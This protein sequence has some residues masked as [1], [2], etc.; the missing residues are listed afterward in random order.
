MAEGDQAPDVYT[1]IPP[2][3]EPK[4][5]GALDFGTGGRSRLA[6]LLRLIRAHP[7]RLPEYMVLFA[8]H[9]QAPSVRE[10]AA[11]HPEDPGSPEHD[12]LL[13]EMRHDLLAFSRING[14]LSGTPFF[15]ALVPAYVSVLRE[16]ARMALRIGALHGRDPGAP[17]RPA[18]A[19]VLL[20]IYPT[21]QAAEDRLE[22]IRAPAAAEEKTGLRQV[23][24]LRAWI[25]VVTQVL[26]LAGFIEPSTDKVKPKRMTRVLKTALAFGLWALTWIVPITFM[27]MMAYACEGRT[28]RVFDR[29]LRFYGD[30][31]VDRADWKRSSS[32]WRRERPLRTALLGL[33]LLI[34]LGLAGYASRTVPLAQAR[35]LLEAATRGPRGLVTSAGALSISA[36]LP[37][38]WL[39]NQSAYRSASGAAL[40]P[41]AKTE[42]PTVR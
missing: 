40:M 24:G 39:S 7:E 19:L 29:A 21:V 42:R 10:W 41:W 12:R 8:T 31:E 4:T 34:P 25:E 28:R 37:G 17:E 11:G 20:D 5:P 22:Q 1:P 36:V 13:R 32:Q 27:L 35:A 38:A 30:V 3:A 26:I 23:G 6:S 33:T 18:E 2:G 15:I 16:Q 9:Q 14:A